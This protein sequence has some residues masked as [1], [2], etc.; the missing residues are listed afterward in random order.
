MNLYIR[1]ESQLESVTTP[2]TLKN[3]VASHIRPEWHASMAHLS[4]MNAH[5]SV[6]PKIGDKGPDFESESSDDDDL[7]IAPP[8]QPT[9]F[10]V[11]EKLSAANPEMIKKKQ[12]EKKLNLEIQKNE[13][14]QILKDRKETEERVR[15][16]RGELEN[17]EE[18]EEDVKER[19][20]DEAKRQAERIRKM[21]I[22]QEKENRDR[23]DNGAVPSD[24]DEDYIDPNEGRD[25]DS[26]DELVV[27]FDEEAESADDEGD[28]EEDDEHEEVD[29]HDDDLEL[30]LENDNQK[31]NLIGLQ[32]NTQK[33][34]SRRR[35]K[36]VDDEDEDEDGGNDAQPQSPKQFT[37]LEAKM[38]DSQ[39]QNSLI[40]DIT[41]S[42]L[43]QETQASQIKRLNPMDESSDEE[44]T[45][46]FTSSMKPPSLTF[47]TSASDIYTQSRTETQDDFADVLPTQLSQFDAPTQ[48][49]IIARPP[50]DLWEGESDEETNRNADIE[51]TQADRFTQSRTQIIDRDNHHSTDVFDTQVINGNTVPVVNDAADTQIISRTISRQNSFA[52][53]LI[54]NNSDHILD[55][56]AE[57]QVIDDANKPNTSLSNSF[58]TS[59]I[60]VLSR[61]F[62]ASKQNEEP[63]PLIVHDSESEE[64]ASNKTSERKLILRKPKKEKK[65]MNTGL[66]KELADEEAVE[67]ED[68]WAGLGGNSDDDIDPEEAAELVAMVDDET[69]LDQ[70]ND[71]T[72]IQKLFTLKQKTKDSELANKLQEIISG[73]WRK[74]QTTGSL[75]ADDD[76]DFEYD[77]NDSARRR[78]MKKLLEKRNRKLLEGNDVLM[79]MKNDPKKRSFVEVIE[80]DI[81]S[82]AAAKVF[83]ENS[84]D[85]D[86]EED[87]DNENSDAK[88]SNSKENKETQD[89]KIIQEE[90]NEPVRKKSKMTREHIRKVLSFLDDDNTQE[91]EWNPSRNLGEVGKEISDQDENMDDI[92]EPF[93][94]P[95]QVP[96]YK[97]KV[98]LYQTTTV[99]DESYDSDEETLGYRKKSITRSF[100][101]QAK[102]MREESANSFSEIMIRDT[103]ST[104]TKSKAAINFSK[105]QPLKMK[106]SR[107]LQ[108]LKSVVNERRKMN[109]MGRKS[110]SFS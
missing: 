67:S 12:E 78:M 82:I 36:V 87:E 47:A 34:T 80:R 83:D 9:A 94:V 92:S 65:K 54:R 27:P 90:L 59:S 4:P 52:T 14:L 62:E 48:V 6:K 57:T 97:R 20:W 108:G 64:D 25:N 69:K 74:K 71:E 91:E 101:E 93:A 10:R 66:G 68:E 81:S 103:A 30:K 106:D 72:T 70:L 95:D 107:H 50:I 40:D 7:E 45:L 1:S 33:S 13:K 61:S 75:L 110:G 49:P 24:D 8:I 104:L 60:Q 35:L 51:P 41:P 58:S 85:E 63:K 44:P 31:E 102:S 56:H 89:D 53:Q 22:A 15:K 86:E 43:F 105:K 19:L 55:I 16:L 42:Q 37:H 98:S 29:E 77:G 23:E 76:D 17:M 109:L 96:V 38:F 88:A 3:S 5:S 73:S 2:K 84:E 99:L 39:S 21:E 46:P 79:Q 18:D 11:L 28:D 100:V 32:D 26:D